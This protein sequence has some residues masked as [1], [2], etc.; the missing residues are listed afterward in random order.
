LQTNQ[1]QRK[2]KVIPQQTNIYL[3]QTTVVLPG[4]GIN[5]P[6]T[7]QLL[8]PQRDGYVISPRSQ[9]NISIEKLDSVINAITSGTPQPLPFANFGEASICLHQGT[10]LSI[11]KEDPKRHENYSMLLN[12]IRIYKG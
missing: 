2:P 8:P 10:I 12:L 6:I 1:S 9:I 4:T 11:L 7:H 3:L 5:L